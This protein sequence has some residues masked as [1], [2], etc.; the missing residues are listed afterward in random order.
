MHTS[1]RYAVLKGS[2]EDW[3]V[4]LRGNILVLFI[5]WLFLDFGS[6]MVSDFQGVYF[7]ALGA[8]DVILGYMG[9]IAFAMLALLQIPGGY[10]A[11]T[12][13]RKRVIVIFTFVMASSMLIF[14]FAPSWQYIVIALIIEN[15][16]LLY[17][18]ALFSII[19]DSLPEEHRSEG[20]AI[21]SLPLLPAL[22][23]PAVGGY[24]AYTYGIVPGMRLA[25]LIVFFLSLIAA[26]L[27][28]SLKETLKKKEERLTFFESIRSL[29][30][31][32]SRAK[33]L[34]YVAI[35]SSFAGGLVDYF[36]VKYA[37][38]YTNGLIFGIAMSLWMIMATL[39]SIPIGKHADLH[40]KEV[41]FAVSLIIYSIAYLTYSLPGIV[42]L[43]S[44]ALLGGL[45]VAM[46]QPSHSGLIADLVSEKNRGRFTGVYLFLS[47]ISAMI[48]SM[49][50][51][52]IYSYDHRIL[53]LT[54]S[55]LMI[56]AFITA[57]F[58]VM[59]KK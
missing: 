50:S 8:S 2:F 49:V 18:P 30:N 52:Y 10:I 42:F 24:F 46:L 26:I 34:V 56:L 28:I 47:Y 33:G 53:F 13:G 21:M 25:Y 7:S 43:F 35:I 9:S 44:F 45:A 32:D 3:K 29:K 40:G 57:Y 15:L 4:I 31:I 14:A 27:R 36:I 19:M 16:A 37:Y 58:L 54:A 59:R 48:G 20:F 51:G 17:Q 1:L 12:F 6:Y 39:A 11:D 5:S 55:I 41:I 23:A 22:V 38:T